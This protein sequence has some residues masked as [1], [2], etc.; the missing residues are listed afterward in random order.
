M[1][2]FSGIAVLEDYLDVFAPGHLLKVLL[3]LQRFVYSVIRH[4]EAPQSCL[5]RLGGLG[6]HHKLG[7]VGHAD[8]LPVQL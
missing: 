8:Q 3:L 6:K 2:W 5:K 7:H 4:A 1:V